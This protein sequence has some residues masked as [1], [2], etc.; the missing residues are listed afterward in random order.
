MFPTDTIKVQVVYGDAL[1][2]AGLSATL[3]GA[4]GFALLERAASTGAAE[5]A[6]VVVT[7]YEHGLWLLAR[8]DERPRYAPPVLIVT[9][10]ES[11]SEIRHALEQGARGYVL[12][13]CSID[14]LVTGVRALC[15]GTRHIAGR[16]AQRLADSVACESLTG[17]EQAVLQLVVVGLGNKAIARRLDIALGTVKSH[18]KSIFQKLDAATRTEVAAIAER[19]GLLSLA[20]A[21]AGGSPGGPPIAA[22][23]RAPGAADLERHGHAAH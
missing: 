10:R 3:R 13:G 11:E 17:R 20:A 5:T 4:P 16:A 12:L 22:G 6:D 15:A 23:L 1:V 8:A 21:C 19:R 9:A 2:A 18:L 7:D 14:E